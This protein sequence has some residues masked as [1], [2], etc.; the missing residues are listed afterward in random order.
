MSWVE[1]EKLLWLYL[2]LVGSRGVVSL[3]FLAGNKAAS[4][5]AMPRYTALVI[6]LIPLALEFNSPGICSAKYWK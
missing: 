2:T 1:T 4:S 3:S 5:I 6:K